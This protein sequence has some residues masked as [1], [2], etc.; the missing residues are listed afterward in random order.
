MSATIQKTK[1]AMRQHRLSVAVLSAVGIGIA[2]LMLAAGG[3]SR[4]NPAGGWMANVLLCL[5]LVV[6]AVSSACLVI[7]DAFH[8]IL[9]H[10]IMG[11]LAVMTLLIML[12][13]VIAGADGQAALW[14]LGIG[15]A[16]GLVLLALAI[17]PGAGL[18]GGD[19]KLAAILAAIV[20]WFNLPALPFA[21][22]SALMSA[23]VFAIIAMVTGRATR[24]TAIALG[25]FLI[26]GAWLALALSVVPS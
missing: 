2:V 21:L 5:G 9:P 26:F 25:P 4:A 17:I 13:A 23:S 3:F 12:M 24:K 11:P 16:T 10:I 14:G 7:T 19:V 1:S 8:H 6:L 15:V 18:G 20:A 22:L